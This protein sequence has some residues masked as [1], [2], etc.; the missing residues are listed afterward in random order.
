[1][2]EK[3]KVSLFSSQEP[4]VC[5]APYCRPVRLAVIIKAAPT[6]GVPRSLCGKGEFGLPPFKACTQATC[7]AIFVLFI[8]FFRPL[9][10]HNCPLNPI[11]KVILN[12][13]RGFLVLSA[14]VLIQFII[15]TLRIHSSPMFA[16]SAT[17]TNLWLVKKIFTRTFNYLWELSWKLRSQKWDVDAP[18][19][20][21]QAPWCED[22]FE[23]HTPKKI[24]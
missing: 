20:V 9:C 18:F 2:A 3:S 16:F 14:K 1:M 15:N 7:R 11:W 21:V 6:Q 22:R 23:V 5:L 10:V 4:I 12:I 13:M 8:F 24:P 17:S 19:L